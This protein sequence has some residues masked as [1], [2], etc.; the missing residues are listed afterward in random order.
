[1]IFQRAASLERRLPV[2]NFTQ[3][4]AD[5]H[6]GTVGGRRNRVEAGRFRAPNERDG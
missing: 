2:G 5:P 6:Y 4:F 3:F 1:M